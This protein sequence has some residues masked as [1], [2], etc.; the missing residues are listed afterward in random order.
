MTSHKSS[1]FVVVAAFALILGTAFGAGAAVRTPRSEVGRTTVEE[2]LKF[3]VD[4]AR[5]GLW[6]EAL[7]RFEQAHRL[8]PNNGRVL[9]NMAV[10]LEAAGRYEDALA[11]YQRAIRLDPANADLKR[12]YAR[13]AEFYQSFKPPVEPGTSPTEPATPSSPEGVPER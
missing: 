12:N 5:R 6:K 13:F 10:A 7:F 4:M 2:Q 3:G 1:G 9:N 11:A 8:D